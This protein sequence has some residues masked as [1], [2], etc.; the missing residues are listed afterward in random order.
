MADKININK[1]RVFVDNNLNFGSPVGIVLDEENHLSQKRRQEI[2]EYVGF[3]E[4]VFIDNLDN[5]EVSVYS[6][7]GH[8]P[9]AGAPLLG[10][11]WFIESRLNKNIENITTMSKQTKVLHDEGLPWIMIDAKDEV[12]LPN[13]KLEMLKSP[14]DVENIKPDE[15]PKDDHSVVWSWIDRTLRVA[16]V[17]A[18][19]FAP[20]W[21][22]TEE[23]AN[24]SG[25]MLLAIKTGRSLL[26]HHGQGSIIRA[27]SGTSGTA[28]GGL[29]KEDPTISI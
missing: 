25:S 14:E 1:V 17:R 28:I 18:R 6:H 19:T 21:N 13:W 11:A 29:V 3:S 9:F 15:R 8:I 24:G 4:T 16:K 10:T 12:I 27:T 5:A 22:I 7:Q 20:G 23:E 2:T 26:I